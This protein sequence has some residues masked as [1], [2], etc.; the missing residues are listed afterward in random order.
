LH[1][2]QKKIGE[3]LTKIFSYQGSP[4]VVY[5]LRILPYVFTRPGELRHAEWEKID[6]ET[7]TWRIPAEKMKMRSPHLVP[8]SSQV[9]KELKELQK[10]RGEGKYLF[11]GARVKTRPITDV[12]INAAL[13]HI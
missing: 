11:P 12:A 5:A 6:F 2:G 8:L 9:I 3:L 7:A 13:T 10:Y 4:S 1:P